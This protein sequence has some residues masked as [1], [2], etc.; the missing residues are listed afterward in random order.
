MFSNHN[1]TDLCFQ[2]G[3]GSFA[4]TK[5]SQQEQLE[6]QEKQRYLLKAFV[7]CSK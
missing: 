6:S 5:Y 3:C 7:I 1:A 4:Q 2:V